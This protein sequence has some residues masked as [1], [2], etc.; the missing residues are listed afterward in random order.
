[1]ISICLH[2]TN[3]AVSY[4]AINKTN[5]AANIIHYKAGGVSPTTTLVSRHRRCVATS[6]KLEYRVMA[7]QRLPV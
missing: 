5:E 7:G 2:Q 3:G 1:V 4:I 6:P